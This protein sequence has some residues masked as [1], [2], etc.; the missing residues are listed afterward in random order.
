MALSF[1]FA[2]W[3][4]RGDNA[5]RAGAFGYRSVDGFRLFQ[6]DNVFRKPYLLEIESAGVYR[7]RLPRSRFRSRSGYRFETYV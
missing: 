6:I 1:V 2:A 4:S 5:D 7:V 3:L